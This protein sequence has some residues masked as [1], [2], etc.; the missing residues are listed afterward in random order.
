MLNFQSSK[1]SY[2]VG[3]NI[4]VNFPTGGAEKALITVENGISVLKSFWVQTSE[5]QTSFEIEAVADMAP[6]I[7]VSISLI[8]PHGQTANDMPIRMYGTIPVNVEDPKSHVHPVID[9]PDEI[10][11]ESITSIKVTEKE[12]REMVYTLAMVDEGLLDLTRFATPNPWKHF[13]AKQALGIK[14][15]D[16]YDNVIGAYGAQ[17]DRILGIGGDGENQKKKGGK[18][19]KRK[20]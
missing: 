13:Y 18:N 9:M 2:K 19:T 10:R 17:L 14:T 8:Q 20:K 16:M 1:S 15:W 7:Y 4:K 6:N 12:G 3:E 11:P 5:K